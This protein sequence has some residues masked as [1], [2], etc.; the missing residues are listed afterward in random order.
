MQ[1]RSATER[2][3]CLFTATC[4]RPLPNARALSLSRS[5]LLLCCTLSVVRV[6]VNLCRKEENK[7]TDEKKEL[8]RLA[9]RKCRA[10][11]RRI[12]SVIKDCSTGFLRLVNFPSMDIRLDQIKSHNNNNNNNYNNNNINE[13]LS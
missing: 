8:P 4:R 3:F 5:L 12:E 9:K 2:I 11:P 7:N 10:A 6:L 1:Q 13:Q